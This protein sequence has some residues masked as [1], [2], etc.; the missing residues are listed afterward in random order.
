M[1]IRGDVL[2]NKDYFDE[3][4]EILDNMSDEE[5]DELLIKSGIENCPYEEGKILENLNNKEYYD[6]IERNFNIKLLPY[7]RKLLDISYKFNSVYN[8]RRHTKKLDNYILLLNR[9]LFMKDDEKITIV[10][11]KEV[12]E[13]SR[14]ELFSWLQNEYWK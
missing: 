14:E 9:A 1:K 13:M 6:F 4:F 8:I 3:V 7:Q 2:D 10:S 5:V 12:K 11:P